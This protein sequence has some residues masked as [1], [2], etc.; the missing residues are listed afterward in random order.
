MKPTLENIDQWL[1]D[2]LEGNLSPAQEQVLDDFIAQHPELEL[3]QEA[4]FKTNYVASEITFEPK[5]AL[6]RKKQFGYKPFA[7]AAVLLLLLAVG[8][9]QNQEAPSKGTLS[10]A[11]SKATLSKGISQQNTNSPSTNSPSTTTLSST[12]STPLVS[13]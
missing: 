10:K 13:S 6:Y 7:A 4:W 2:A 11:P 3:E 1:F 8:F 5:A 12:P 9:Y